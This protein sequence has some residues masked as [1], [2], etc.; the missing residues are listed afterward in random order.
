MF[1]LKRASEQDYP[2]IQSLI[3]TT[4]KACYPAIY[5]PEIIRFYLDYH[6]LEEIY[7]R[8]STGVVLALAMDNFIRATGF[9]SQSEMGGVYVHPEYQRK[10]LGT[11]I[12][13]NLFDIAL[14][15]KLPRIWLDATPFARPLYE[16]LG[17]MTVNPSV[18]FIEGKPLNYFKMEKLLL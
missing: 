13:K 12:I 8:A 2:D 1:T 11:I 3:Y 14:E 17:F 18:M 6:S 9:L 10:G 4:V 16:K 15:Q 5:A 7:R